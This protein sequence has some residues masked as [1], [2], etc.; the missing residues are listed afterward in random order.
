RTV[1]L[2]TAVGTAAACTMPVALAGA[3]GFVLTGIRAG[4]DV[5]L[6]TGYVYWPAVLGISLA[7]V[8]TAPLGARLAHSLPVEK[9]RR[10]FAVLLVIVGGRM[11]FG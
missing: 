7:S 3:T 6:A 8:L 11:L 9:L 2:H 1:A 4:S 10:A 5:G